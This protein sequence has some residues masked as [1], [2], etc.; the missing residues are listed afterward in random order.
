M[1]LTSTVSP[2]FFIIT[3]RFDPEKDRPPIR[4]QLCAVNWAT[5][6]RI[7]NILNAMAPIRLSVRDPSSSMRIRVGPTSSSSLAALLQLTRQRSHRIEV[8]R[9]VETDKTQFYK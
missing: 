2:Y 6:R 3:S 7:S 5:G 8:P 1:G 9:Y 4:A